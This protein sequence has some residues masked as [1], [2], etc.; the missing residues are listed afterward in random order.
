[1]L[2]VVQ[3]VD[4]SG[5]SLCS[6]PQSAREIDRGLIVFLGV[7]CEDTEEDVRK[8]VNKLAKIRV[9]PDSEG[10]I[11]LDI[12][13][14]KGEVM[15]ISQFTLFGDVSKSNRPSFVR[16]APKDQ[17]LSLYNLFADKLN[18]IGLSVKEGYFGEHMSI[19]STLNGPITII[20][21]SK[22]I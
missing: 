16:A 8:L 18:Q 5:V 22:K 7:S 10:K 6:K 3:V 21:D 13:T 1:M 19:T 15:L 9:F 12:L 17:A 14:T 20:I 11:N 2:V 4:R